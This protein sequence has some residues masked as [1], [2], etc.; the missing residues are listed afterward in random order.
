[1]HLQNTSLEIYRCM[2]L[3]DN[4][5]VIFRAMFRLLVA[6]FPQRL[7][8][9]EPGSGPVGFVVNKVALW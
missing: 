9:F 1:M 8:V 4:F 6:A 3:S 5:Y 2:N 7:P